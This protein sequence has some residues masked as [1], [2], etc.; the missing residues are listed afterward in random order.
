VRCFRRRGESRRTSAAP[1]SATKVRYA[2]RRTD[3][4]PELREYI[5]NDRLD[6]FSISGS[7]RYLSPNLAEKSRRADAHARALHSRNNERICA[8]ILDVRFV[9]NPNRRFNSIPSSRWRIQISLLVPIE[10][11]LH[12]LR[13]I[14][15]RGGS[16]SNDRIEIKS[17]LA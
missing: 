9:L 5:H 11:K 13:A 10:L 8:S 15:T 1:P 14:V 7:S 4:F 12:A 17:R 6:R 3:T 16:L 2:R